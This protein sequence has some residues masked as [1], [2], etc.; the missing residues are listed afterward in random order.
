MSLSLG[1]MISESTIFANSSIPAWA[2]F[3]R[4]P[5]NLNGR[6]TTATVRM[7]F[8]LATCATTGAAPV[9]VPP[10]MPAVMKSMSAPPMDST[11]RSR[12]SIAASRPISGRAP[13]PSPRVRL[14]PS[15]NCVR[16]V[17]RLSACA[18][19]LA[20]MNSTPTTPLPIM[21]SIALPPQP[22]TPMTL[23]TASCG[24]WSII[25]NMCTPFLSGVNPAACSR[26]R[27]CLELRALEIRLEPLLHP[28]RHVGEPAPL[29]TQQ[30]CAQKMLASVEQ[31]TDRSRVARAAYDI[32]QAADVRRHSDTHR[33]M[34]DLLAQLDHARQQCRAAGEHDAR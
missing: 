8:S 18:S 10:P 7:P 2:T 24:L 30:L 1:M 14:V 29:G 15:C 11:M 19:V 33:Q 6:V 17:E 23:I 5:S 4:L 34:K 26:L 21:C 32:G 3:C 16:A 22:P 27:P 13:A 31:Q 20:A 25:S 28:P 12:S 9:P